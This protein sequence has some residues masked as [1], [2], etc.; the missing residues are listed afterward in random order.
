MAQIFE[1]LMPQIDVALWKDCTTLKSYQEGKTVTLLLPL[2]M[3]DMTEP[4][5]L[6][7]LLVITNVGMP[8]FSLEYLNGHS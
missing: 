4:F 2:S 6:Y 3:V 7:W 8:L 1:E 5:N